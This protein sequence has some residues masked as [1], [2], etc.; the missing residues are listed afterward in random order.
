MKYLLLLLI[1]SFSFSCGK[2]EK[3]EK[4]DK[5]AE[6]RNGIKKNYWPQGS[7]FSEI[8][9]KNGLKNGV[10]TEYWKNGKVHNIYNFKDNKK[11][12]EYKV[13]WQ[14]SNNLREWGIFQNDKFH[15]IKKRY[16]KNGKLKSEMPFYTGYPMV[17]LKEYKVNGELRNHP[18]I[19]ISTKDEIKLKSSFTV[20][21]SLTES[22]E[23]VTVTYYTGKLREGKYFV[24]FEDAIPFETN[25]RIGY[26]RYTVPPGKFI[27]EELSIIGVVKTSSD[28]QLIL[29]EPYK[30]KIENANY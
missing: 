12:G 1:I 20:M 3:K 2:K 15:G 24:A 10:S 18:T 17:G 14:E 16:S 26:L 9:F 27:S 8:S 6:V 21:A 22:P 19:V 29:I 23:T 11:H 28:N 7:L 25:N 13:Y 30:V 4:I 5:N